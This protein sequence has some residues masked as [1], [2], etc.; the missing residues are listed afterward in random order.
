MSVWQMQSYELQRTRR[1]ILPLLEDT[2]FRLG[3]RLLTPF[4]QAC[5]GIRY[6][7][8]AL[9]SPTLSIKWPQEANQTYTQNLVVPQT[10]R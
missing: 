5:L 7:A 9:G 6:G 10:R 4:G 1:M 2:R 8:A 3:E